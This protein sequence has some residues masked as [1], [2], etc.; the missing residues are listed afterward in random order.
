[1]VAN[2]REVFI[3]SSVFSFKFRLELK[4][5]LVSVMVLLLRSWWLGSL[6]SRSHGE[7]L[8]SAADSLSKVEVAAT[9]QR[10][11]E[12]KAQS[13]EH[14]RFQVNHNCC[15]AEEKVELSH[16]SFEYVKHVA[17]GVSGLPWNNAGYF[18]FRK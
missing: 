13:G 16:L 18:N 4:Y 11:G 6:S 15:R 17:V 14:G 1:M 10:V 5:G 8:S 3:Q 7:S 12:L 2:H 9:D